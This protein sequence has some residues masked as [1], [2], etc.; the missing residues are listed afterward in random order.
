MIKAVLFDLDDTLLGNNMDRF[1]P[2]YFEML[3]NYIAP[4]YPKDKFLQALLAGTD[5]MVTN[6]NTA[7]SNRDAFWQTF[8]Q[9]TGQGA[10]EL[11]EYIHTFYEEQFPRLQSVTEFRPQAADLVQACLDHDWQ[12]VIAT[13]PLF[14]RIAIEHRLDW[15]GVPATKFPY[16]LI[17]TYE[18]MSATKPHVAYYEQILAQLGDGFEAETAVM[19]GNDWVNDIEPAAALGMQTYW[20]TEKDNPPPDSSLVTAYGSLG[21]LRQALQTGHL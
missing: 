17:T 20:L 5:A 19:I 14:P 1:I 12:V 11:E 9:L 7:V 8:K 18:N 2:P 21:Q 3:G 15:A 13:N 10:D 16:A 4:R 6:Q